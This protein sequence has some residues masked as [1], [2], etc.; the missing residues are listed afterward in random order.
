MRA[1]LN[2]VVGI[3]VGWVLVT[4]TTPAAA[5]GSNWSMSDRYSATSPSAT[6]QPP[7]YTPTPH[8]AIQHHAST[9]FEGRARG[10]AAIMKAYA[11]GMLSLSQAR[12]LMAEGHAREMQNEVIKT[13]TFLARRNS[14]KEDF[15]ERTQR[16]WEWLETAR[17]HRAEREQTVLLEAYHVPAKQLNRLTGEITWPAALTHPGLASHRQDT[18]AV[19]TQVASHG[20]EYARSY[21][22]SMSHTIASFRDFL[23][24]HRQALG[25]NAAEYFDAQSFL[26]GLKYEAQ[27]WGA[28]DRLAMVASR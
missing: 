9:A 23:R 6:Y 4:V 2:V 25:W 12:I 14:L 16:R 28:S 7:S 22:A 21:G 20:A 5:Q 17:Q 24:Q 8:S 3:V 11:D 19:M 15:R 10:I 13:E 1:L 18:Q 26:V 27:F